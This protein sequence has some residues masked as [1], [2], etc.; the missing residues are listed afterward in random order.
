VGLGPC[1]GRPSQAAPNLLRFL[2]D[3]TGKEPARLRIGDLDAPAILSFLNHVEQQRNNQIQSR[4]VRL[5]AIR[6]F[7]RLVA[8]QDPASIQFVTSVLAI[9]GFSWILRAETAAIASLAI[10]DAAGRVV[11]V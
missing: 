9:P 4:N 10:I 11:P 8:L 5:A 2:R 1:S 6:S 3:S 7:F